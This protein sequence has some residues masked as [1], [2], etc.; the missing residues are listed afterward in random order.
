LA[1]ITA[2]RK[3][4]KA[5]GNK[6]TGVFCDAAWTNKNRLPDRLLKIY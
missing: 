6:L 3:I 2:F 5:N 1:I 4:E